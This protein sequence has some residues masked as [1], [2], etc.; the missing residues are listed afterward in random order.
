MLWIDPFNQMNVTSNYCNYPQHC[1]LPHYILIWDQ[2][3]W[4]ENFWNFGFWS[5]L[6]HLCDGEISHFGL[7]EIHWILGFYRWVFLIVLLELPNEYNRLQLISNLKRL[8]R[9]VL[10]NILI[11]AKL[12]WNTIKNRMKK[13]QNGFF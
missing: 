5:C 2:N 8:N 1:Q 9:I 11:T 7:Y 6:K 12:K 4:V 13:K 10:N 3:Q